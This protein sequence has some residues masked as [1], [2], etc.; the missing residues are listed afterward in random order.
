MTSSCFS[1]KASVGLHH[2][3]AAEPFDVNLHIV[4]QKR[5]KFKILKK[6]LPSY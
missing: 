6:N 5:K 3:V 2:R 4:L 1:K